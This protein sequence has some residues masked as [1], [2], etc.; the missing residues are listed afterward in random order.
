MWSCNLKC[1]CIW[2]SCDSGGDCECLCTAIAAYA[3]ECN[4]RGVYIR[5]RSQELCRMYECTT[6]AIQKAQW[7][8]NA[9]L[10]IK[11][12]AKCSGIIL[13]FIIHTVCQFKITA[14]DW[15]WDGSSPPLSLAMQCEDGLVYEACGSACSDVC[16]GS[17]PSADSHCSALS[18]VEGCFCP[19][20]T[21][22]HGQD[23]IPFSI[24]FKNAYCNCD[25]FLNKY[26][27]LALTTYC[28]WF[29]HYIFN[30]RHRGL[31]TAVTNMGHYV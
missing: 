1:L 20:G 31:Y 25:R 22:R 26:N 24:L 11:N 4:R 5:W 2:C 10:F 18:C 21:V 7:N 6:I 27:V 17:S 14:Y 9:M 13:P 19:Q 29:I 28:A 23:I 15:I 12:I 30:F 16:P 3:E 8:T